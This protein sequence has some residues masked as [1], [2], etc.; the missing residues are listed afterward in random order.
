MQPA[1]A[2]TP[3]DLYRVNYQLGPA[4]N[5]LS[6]DHVGSV[7]IIASSYSLLLLS[8]SANPLQTTISPIL[9]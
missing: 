7:F 6:T 1:M 8:I 5:V 2:P 4:N 9:L 3:D